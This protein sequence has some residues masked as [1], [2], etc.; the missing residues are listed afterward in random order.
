MA[1]RYED[2][3]ERTRRFMLE[4]VEADASQGFLYIS[5]RLNTSGQQGFEQ[6]LKEA[7][8]E[9]DDAWLAD[10]LRYGDYLNAT[11]Q[12]QTKKG[13]TMQ[14]MPSNAPDTLAEGEFNRFYI[15]GLCRR[16]IEDGIN[17]VEVYRGRESSRPRPESEAMIGKRLPAYVLLEDLRLS[18]GVEPALGLPPGP[19]SGLTVRLPRG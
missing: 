13:V 1:L 2:L 14:K 8:R 19:N 18:P 11:L 15:R 17:E 6:L 9:H 10:Q 16:A 3:D 4:E 5:P 12:R 7:V